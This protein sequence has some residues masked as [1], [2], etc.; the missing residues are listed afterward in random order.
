[1]NFMVYTIRGTFRTRVELT[2]YSVDILHEISII[3]NGA[4]V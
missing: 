4:I 2:R 3:P 1:M